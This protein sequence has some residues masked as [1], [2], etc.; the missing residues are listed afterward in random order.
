[1]NHPSR[2]LLFYTHALERGGAELVVAILAS[3]FS[4]R[5]WQVTVA[6][7]RDVDHGV[8]LSPNVRLVALGEGHL[9]SMNALTALIRAE[10]P[11]VSFSA[12]SA[13]NLKHAIAAL[14]AGRRR[15]AV[16]SYHGYF[17]A[18]PHLLSRAG[19]LAVPI[20]SRLTAR[21]VCVSDGLLRHLRRFLASTQRSLR[22]YNP[23]RLVADATPSVPPLVERPPL[24]L[25]VG[26]LAPV[27]RYVDLIRA[28]AKLKNPEARLRIVGEGLE[29]PTIEAEAKALG[30]QDRIELPGYS[31]D[32]RPHYRDARLL[33]LTSAS[34]SF[35][36]VVVEALSHGLPVVATD[37]GG[38]AEI[39]DGPCCGTIVSI[40]D[41]KAIAEAIEAT[42]HAPGDPEPRQARSAAFSITRATN[43]FEAL[44]DDVVRAA[45]GI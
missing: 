32:V 23:V 9:H 45:P 30:V 42:L 21:T 40:G 6:V 25:A 34:E 5:G 36:N 11:D 12:L 41:V 37:C 35:G 27:K 38:P 16:I 13:S 22:I 15:R 3:A 1:M 24:V 2:K 8:K 4:E 14:R 20:L 43:A 10:K 33:V 18:E 28:F 39:I 44:F 7:D 31:P 29:R 17:Q 19:F 26:R